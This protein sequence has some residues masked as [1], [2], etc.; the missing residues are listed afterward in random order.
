MWWLRWEAV[1]WLTKLMFVVMP[2][3]VER[4][5]IKEVLNA[6]GREHR[7]RREARQ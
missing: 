7:R 3:S 2:K 1:Y 4:D 6:W 5:E